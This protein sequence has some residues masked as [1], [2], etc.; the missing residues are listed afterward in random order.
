M[1]ANISLDRF[2][3][4]LRFSLKLRVGLPLQER[5]FPPQLLIAFK[6]PGP[7]PALRT[8]QPGSRSW[9]TVPKLTLLC[10]FDDLGKGII[11][12]FRVRPQLQLS[13]SGKIHQQPF[14]WH[15]NQ[16]A[17]GRRVAPFA[18]CLAHRCCALSLFAE[19]AVGDRGFTGAG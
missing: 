6:T 14:L 7:S 4:L 12:V 16:L 11:D 9:V 3:F 2:P 5:N 17:A 10:Q 19:Q 13:Q 18:I 8:A 15:E 1:R